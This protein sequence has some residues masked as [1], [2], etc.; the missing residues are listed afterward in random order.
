MFS[1][2]NSQ[3][4]GGL[5]F[6]GSVRNYS[7]VLLKDL[8]TIKI[9]SSLNQPSKRKE[10]LKDIADKG[11]IVLF[12]AKD[13]KKSYAIEGANDLTSFLNNLF[14]K[15]YL[16][17]MANLYAKEAL[18]PRQEIRTYYQGLLSK[19]WKNYDLYLLETWEINQDLDFTT[20]LVYYHAKYQPKLNL[21]RYV[22]LANGV[23]EA[24]TQFNYFKTQAQ[25][26]AEKQAKDELKPL[27]VYSINENSP[28]SKLRGKV[29]FDNKEKAG[30]YCL[31]NRITHKAYV[32]SSLNLANATNYYFNLQPWTKPLKDNYILVK[33]LKKYGLTNFNLEI[34]TY[35]SAEELKE[36]ELYYIKLLNPQYNP[37]RPVQEEVITNS[38]SEPCSIPSVVVPPS[39]PKVAK[40]NLKVAFPIALGSALI[41][42]PANNSKLAIIRDNFTQ[43]LALALIPSPPPE[44]SLMSKNS[45]PVKAEVVLRGDSPKTWTLSETT[46]QKQSLA[47]QQRTQQPNPGFSVKVFDLKAK[48]TILYATLTE[49]S[50]ALK[51]N[52]G[53]LSRRIKAKLTKPYQ[54]RYVITKG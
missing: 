47:R 17:Y 49:A 13:S 34:L 44:N 35:C 22:S 54:K 4:L 20:R 48:Q 12:L 41:S 9:Y 25:I 23:I 42:A 6:A 11:G 32:G 1:L 28:L 10:L 33:A 14:D 43:P 15:D 24:V 52:K 38:V 45:E 16:E 51:I 29:W 19:G 8:K 5:G 46:R 21:I 18:K 2:L 27:T 50:L 26:F 3:Q 37:K 30:I 31:V 40:D 7:S 36:K 53:T 39:P